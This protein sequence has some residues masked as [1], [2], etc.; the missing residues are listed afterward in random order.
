[1]KTSLHNIRLV[2]IAVGIGVLCATTVAFAQTEG[3]ATFISA[4]QQYKDIAAERISVVVP[5]V[6]EVPFDREFL[7][8]SDFAV[9]DTTANR[10]EPSY[11]IETTTLTPLLATS[12]DPQANAPALVDGDGTSYASFDVPGDQAVQSTIRIVASRSVTASALTFELENNVALP[13]TIAIRAGDTEFGQKVVVAEQRLDSTAVHFPKT[14]ARYWTV[15]LQHVQP[16]R[17]DELRLVEDASAGTRSLR[18]LAQPNRS[19]RVY[20][21][22]D[23]T[24]LLPAGESGNLANANGVKRIGSSPAQNN[25]AYIPA[26]VDGD[27]IPDVR[28]NCASISNADQADIDE[29]G[30]GDACQDFDG[31]GIANVRDNCQD[32]PNAGQAD[33]DGDESGDACDTEE[34][35]LTE[36]YT[37]IPWVGIG[38][39]AVVIAILFGLTI[40][41]RPNPTVESGRAGENNTP[42]V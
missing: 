39:A 24:V 41:M 29:N 6:V 33:T 25:S 2:P 13:A 11:F 30:L 18:F 32:I 28:D 1:M 36:K 5:T 21:N 10:F 8:R 23:R 19:Y 31:D 14:R 16:L 35:R 42:A 17:I 12:D 27:S 40:S 15:E 3:L 26:D 22:P 7:E 20:F 34:S 37:W 38:F 4:Y 9:L